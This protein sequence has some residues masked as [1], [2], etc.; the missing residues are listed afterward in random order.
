[1]WFHV[2]CCIPPPPGA[3]SPSHDISLRWNTPF[4][5]FCSLHPPQA[6]QKPPKRL[7]SGGKIDVFHL[8]LV[9]QC[10]AMV[11]AG[12]VYSQTSRSFVNGLR[13]LGNHCSGDAMMEVGELAS[14]RDAPLCHKHATVASPAGLSGQVLQEAV[15]HLG[16]AG[17]ESARPLFFPTSVPAVIQLILFWF[18]VSRFPE[19]GAD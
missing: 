17:G 7:Y 16:G 13:E 18:F 2:T 5:C 3:G 6:P 4:P 11:E 12:R 19:K 15:G 1:M 9:K 8:Q 14:R 10:Q